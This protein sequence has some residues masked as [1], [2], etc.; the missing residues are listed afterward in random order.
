M[1][2]P[3]FFLRRLFKWVLVCSVLTMCWLNLDIWFSR[4]ISMYDKH[5]SWLHVRLIWGREN[6]EN[7]VELLE[8][9]WSDGFQL[10]VMESRL[11]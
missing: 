7:R 3:T 1:K 5:P 4:G 6:I 11:I 8:L 9:W 10:T 2:L